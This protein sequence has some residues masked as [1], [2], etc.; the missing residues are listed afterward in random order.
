MLAVGWVHDGWAPPFIQCLNGPFPVEG[1]PFYESTRVTGEQT[2]FPLGV[3]C[4]Y[5]VEGDAFGP[6]V[7]HNYNVVPTV[8]LVVSLLGVA[9]GL[10][11]IVRARRLERSRRP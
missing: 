1:G 8:V 9:G 10:W 6:Q 7:I 2:L 4:T 5:D 11:I 3:D